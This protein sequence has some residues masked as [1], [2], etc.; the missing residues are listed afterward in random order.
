MERIEG[1]TDVDNERDGLTER[2]ENR[3]TGIE[4]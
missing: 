1:Q 4:R 3:R 2:G